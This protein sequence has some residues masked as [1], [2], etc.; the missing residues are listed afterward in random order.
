MAHD[1]FMN[2]FAIAA[3][4]ACAFELTARMLA[5]AVDELG[6]YAPAEPLDPLVKRIVGWMAAS[7]LGTPEA[8]D[9][10]TGAARVR[11]KLLHLELSRVTGR[12]V[13]LGEQLE[14]GGVTRVD[15]G[16]EKA[17]RVADESL[18]EG[19]VLGWLLE[20]TRSGAFVAAERLFLR[21]IITLESAITIYTSRALAKEVEP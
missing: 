21:S 11:N 3:A 12:L 20:S 7:D 18:S 17:T 14:R 4:A 19:R 1:P 16:T 2:A 15:L 5:D 8:R 9:E 13:E 6:K 10:L